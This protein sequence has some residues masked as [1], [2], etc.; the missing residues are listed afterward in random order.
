FDAP[1]PGG[2][3]DVADAGV[4]EG[5]ERTAGAFAD[6]I[7]A[8]RAAAQARRVRAHGLEVGGQARIA[9]RQAGARIGHGFVQQCPAQHQQPQY[10]TD[11]EHAALA[12]LPRLPPGPKGLHQPAPPRRRRPRTPSS[13]GSTPVTSTARPSVAMD[14]RKAS[15][16]P[17]SAVTI[18]ISMASPR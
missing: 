2:Q 10:G 18:S 4:D 9:L 3:A 12:W 1:E 6:G 16:C 13:C 15:S 14:S 17:T 5:E 11:T 7:P 8:G